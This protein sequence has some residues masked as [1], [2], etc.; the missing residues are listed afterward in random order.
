LE[1]D[2]EEQEEAEVVAPTEEEIERSKYLKEQIKP[3]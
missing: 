3:E 2:F 1:R